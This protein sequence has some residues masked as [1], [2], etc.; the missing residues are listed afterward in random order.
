M[1]RVDLTQPLSRGLISCWVNES[2]ALVRIFP[3][4]KIPQ[5]SYDLPDVKPAWLPLQNSTGQTLKPIIRCACGSLVGIGLHHVHADGMVTA[6]FYH[7][8]P[9]ESEQAK[10]HQGCGFHEMLELEGWTGGDFPPEPR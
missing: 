10:A 4:M 7:W 6:S 1:A 9:P 5:G 8:W 2:D 3:T